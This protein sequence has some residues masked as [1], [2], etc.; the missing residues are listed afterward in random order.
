MNKNTKIL[1]LI[2]HLSKENQ[3]FDLNSVNIVRA[4]FYRSF[5]R[6][7]SPDEKNHYL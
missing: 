1:I 4:I 3:I 2:G 6:S 5:P 7:L